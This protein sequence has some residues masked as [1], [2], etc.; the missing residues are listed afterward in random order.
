MD[1]INDGKC[2]TT[3][4]PLVQFAMYFGEDFIEAKKDET[5]RR[6]MFV[7]LLT[8]KIKELR[9][10]IKMNIPIVIDDGVRFLEVQRKFHVTVH[11]VMAES[12]DKKET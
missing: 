11:T 6:C 12:D 3:E 7:F 1:R 10:K 2:Y 4:M 8:D 9:H 5:G